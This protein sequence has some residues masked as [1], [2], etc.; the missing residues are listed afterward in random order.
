[1]FKAFP[2]IPRIENEKYHFTEKIDGTNAC[3]IILPYAEEDE[4]QRV[5]IDNGMTIRCQSR[6]RLITPEEDNFGFARWVYENGTELTSL[7]LGYHY[8]EWWG[9]GIQRGYNMEEKVFSLFLYEHELPTPLVRRVPKLDVN[10]IEEAKKFLL[11]N[12]SVAAPGWTK[13]E[14]AVMYCEQTKQ[15][16]KII[17]DK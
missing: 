2:K 14:G 17:I 6:T 16:Y 1:M 12:G 9:K 7:G 11:T 15:H 5:F 13:P 4:T 3:I 10:S 8:G